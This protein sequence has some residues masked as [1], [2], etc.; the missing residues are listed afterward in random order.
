MR[1]LR[2]SLIS[3]AFVTFSAVG[4]VPA[5]AQPQPPNTTGIVIT[6]APFFIYPD[7]NRTPLGTLP[8]GTRVNVQ[9]RDGD[10]YRIVVHDLQWGD[11]TGYMRVPNVRLEPSALATVRPRGTSTTTPSGTN[12]TT[13]TAPPP[14]QPSAVPLQSQSSSQERPSADRPG[15]GYVSVNGSFQ[16]TSTA[17]DGISISTIYAETATST[18]AY[19]V[20]RAPTV[21][22][23]GGVWVGH[24]LGFGGA[25]NWM[26]QRRGGA[27][28]ANQ[29][30]PFL[31]NAVRTASGD[32]STLSRDEIGIHGDAIWGLATSPGFQLS[33]F[34]GPSYFRLKQDLVTGIVVNDGYP[35]DAITISGTTIAP[36]AKWQVG[37][38]VGADVSTMFSRSVGVGALIRYSHASM[39]VS[40]DGSP[41]VH[42]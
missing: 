15:R 18:A 13:T 5:A 36:A 28:T 2:F 1:F 11:R 39:H 25:V 21:D 23:G 32:V 6:D 20:G 14:S 30:N 27:V 10:W 3:F 26:T 38:N 31:F 33:V 9:A 22:I 35:F 4:I 40:A 42:T 34:G 7:A 16:T 41:E 8:A 12:P 37:F 19:T 17:F 24:R 29:P